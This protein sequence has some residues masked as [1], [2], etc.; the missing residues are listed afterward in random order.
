V[1]A[2]ALPP[3]SPAA[4]PWAL[5]DRVLEV[6]PGRRAVGEKLVSANEPYFV[7]HFPGAPVFPGV[8]LCEA[9]AQL[10]TVVADDATLRLVG[11]ERARFRRPVL[12]GEVLHLEVRALADG[13]PWRLRGVATLGEA[14]VAEVEFTA[15]PPVG[16][17]IHPRAVVS[18]GAELDRGVTIEAYAVIGPHVRIGAGT[19]IGPHAVVEGRTTLGARNR[20][21]QFASVGAVPQDLKYRGEASTL[22]V[23]DDNIVR[24]YASLN[25]GTAGGGMV[26]RVGSGCLLMVSSHVAHDCIV[27]SNVIL[28]NGAALGGHVRV[29]DWGIV[30]GL[31]GVHQYVR[32][33]E[34]AL[35]AA[36]AMVSQDVPPFCTAAGDRA[37]LRGLNL[38]G[39]R[40]RGF[41][42][43][44]VVA[45]KR[46]YRALFGPGRTTA[47]RRDALARVR[48]T[49]GHVPEVVRLVDFVA[50][51]ERGV[52][53]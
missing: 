30:G 18:P 11:V 51:S 21:F 41:S 13:P 49:L 45:L 39:L 6:E 3:P 8:V 12:P 14:L 27:G 17:R 34:S 15:A 1:T 5:V 7:G 38:V 4:F 23:G 9:L 50:E 42:V 46:A 20:I 10:A 48:D 24:E 16:V 22:E 2:A 29:D 47:A 36:G 43:D 26:T 53:R 40:R 37:R 19:H 35:C 33:G 31:A 32:V 44:A 52:G 25:P 28:A